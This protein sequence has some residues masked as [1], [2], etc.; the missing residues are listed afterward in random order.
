MVVKALH[1]ASRNKNFRV[2]FATPYENQIRLI[3]T[4]LNELLDSSPLLKSQVVSRTKNPFA[5]HFKNGSSII[6]FTTGAATGSGAAS[7]RGQ[8][9][10]YIFMDEVDKKAILSTINSVKQEKSFLKRSSCTKLI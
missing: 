4:R 7:I 2:L 9:A 1:L 6:G 10:D 5:I 3:F 8:A